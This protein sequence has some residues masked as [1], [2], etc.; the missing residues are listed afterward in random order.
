MACLS[1]VLI[2]V[3][4]G[5]DAGGA[6]ANAGLPEPT[7]T[8]ITIQVTAAAI[9]TRPAEYLPGS[10]ESTKGA[11]REFPEVLKQAEGVSLGRAI[12]TWQ[13]YLNDG[14]LEAGD[15]IAD[16]CEN[17]TGSAEWSNISGD[18]TW[19]LGPPPLTDNSNEVL[20]QIRSVVQRTRARYILSYLD[21]SPVLKSIKHIDRYSDD[22]VT[23]DGE[24][25][26]FSVYELLHCP[27][28]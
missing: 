14:V 15:D 13:G 23:Y 25:I 21:E 1:L 24:P 27:N 3:A 20:F 7:P 9:E 6:S 19:T 5:S 12:N 28:P 26:P 17:S 11:F 18:I 22:P 10:G 8:Y 2:L 4:C 16:L